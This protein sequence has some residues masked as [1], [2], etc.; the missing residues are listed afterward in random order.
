MFSSV[1][2]SAQHLTLK[3]GIVTDS[4]IV[5]NASNETFTVYLPTS[6]TTEKTWPIIVI[7]DSEGRGKIVT[8]LFKK[9]GEEQAYIIA[10]SNNVSKDLDLL[11][12]VEIGDRLIETVQAYFSIDK[13]AIYTTG[14]NAGAE[15][16]MAVSAIRTDIKGVMAIGDFWINSEF[17]KKDKGY[18]FVGMIDYK[19]P[20]YYRLSDISNYISKIGYPSRI[21]SFTSAKEYPSADLIYSGISEF[22][23]QRLKSDSTVNGNSAQKLFEHDLRIAEN[24]RRKLSFYEAYE[25]LDLMSQ[26]FPVEGSQDIIREMQK[27]IKKNKIYRSQRRNFAKAITTENIKKSEFSYYLADDLAQINFENLGYWNQQ[28]KE[29]EEN[30][31]SENIAEARMGYRLQGYLQN[32]AQLSLVQFEEQGSS[33]DLLVFTAVLQTIFDKENP[34]GYFKII[35]LSASDGDYETALLYLEDLLKTGY[36]NLDALYTIPGT[37]DLKLSPEYNKVIKKYLGRSKFYNLNLEE[38]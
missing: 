15:A 31:S 13:N 22:T 33:I 3:K 30:K 35:S 5:A 14:S 25:F 10:A 7:F 9:I 36:D 17:L 1:L 34:K 24:L 16:A 4:L 2:I 19:D 8:Q 27:E 18:A 11:K 23:L 21:Y 28:I 12:N 20:D 37:L 26:K 29:L 32:M 6:Y 38:N